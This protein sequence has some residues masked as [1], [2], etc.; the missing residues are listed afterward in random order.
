MFNWLKKRFQEKSTW[1]GATA[2]V[3]AAAQVASMMPGQKD[4]AS[5][6]QTATDA[7]SHVGAGVVAGDYTGAAVAGVSAAFAMF[8]TEKGGK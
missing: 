6:L 5:M 1:L 3:G 8:T 4:T 2:L 7:V